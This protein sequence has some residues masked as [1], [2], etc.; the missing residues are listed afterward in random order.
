M[1]RLF[2]AL[3][4][5]MIPTGAFPAEPDSPRFAVYRVD[6]PDPDR[7]PWALTQEY[8][9]DHGVRHE[10]PV[11]TEKHLLEYCWDTQRLTLTAEGVRRWESQGGFEVPLTGLPLVVCLD[12]EPRYA[13]MLWNP[14]S[15]MGCRLPE[16]WCKALEGRIRIGGMFISAEGDTILGP[17]YDPEIQKVLTE[18]GKLSDNCPEE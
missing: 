8:V 16:I 2:C 1:K 17:N 4:L 14:L 3:V 18:L 15:S 7:V 5:L 13:A 6:M 12:D 9:L 11:L 10:S